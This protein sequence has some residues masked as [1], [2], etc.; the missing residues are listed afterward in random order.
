MTKH[1]THVTGTRASEGQDYLH[2]SVF[3]G[4]LDAIVVCFFLGLG[5]WLDSVGVGNTGYTPLW[6]S[7]TAK[8]RGHREGK[9]KH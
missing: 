4:L 5:A 3:V 7:L 9:K 2:I 6:S 8:L 1:L